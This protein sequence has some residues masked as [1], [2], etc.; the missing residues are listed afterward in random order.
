[1][2]DAQAGASFVL[3]V[4]DEPTI[5]ALIARTLRQHAFQARIALRRDEVLA[6]AGDEACAAVLLD[7]GLPDDD[8]MDI[9]RALRERSDV[10]ILMLTGRAAVRERVSGLEAGADDYIVKPFDSEELVARL[11]AVLRRKP[12][13]ERRRARA[14]A[15]L[16]G[17]GR[18]DLATR[19]FAGP[20]GSEK[21]TEQETRLLR[22]MVDNDGPLARASAYGLVFG[23]K[24]EPTDRSLDVHVA[25][26]RRKLKAALGGSDPIA[27]L[28][29]KG[30][31]LSAPAS[32]EV[33]AEA[34][35]GG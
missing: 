14:V 21:L 3:V 25:N 16:L 31:E 34:E 19:E 30:Y 10:P 6:L 27:T 2:S 26:L 32:V 4:E 35:D 24:W 9:A 33:E 29:G 17:A 5:Q 18:L 15:I 8:G 13:A 28:R 1:M 11:R 22:A 12:R 20:S 7:L 23:R